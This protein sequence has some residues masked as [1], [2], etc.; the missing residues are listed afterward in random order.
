[1]LKQAFFMILL[2]SLA[3]PTTGAECPASNEKCLQEACIR[4]GGDFNEDS[5]CVKGANFDE[6]KYSQDLEVCKQVDEFCVENDGLVH[7]MS[8]CGPIFI[9][10]AALLLLSRGD[11]TP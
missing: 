5:Y 8:C 7:N 1:M 4:A 3:F 9:L 2:L 11:G 6:T 10:L